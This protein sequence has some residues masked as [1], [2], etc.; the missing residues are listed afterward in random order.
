[1]Q[2]FLK[3]PLSYS[4]LSSW[5]WSKEG[6]Y[7]SYIKGERTSPNSIMLAGSRIGDAIGTESCPIGL[8]PPGVKEYGITTVI[9]DIPLV[10]YFDH[11]C[12]KTRVLHENK[13]S[14]NKS[15]WTQ[16][17]VDKHSQIDMYLLLLRE[18]E[19][20]DPES[21]SCQLNFV[22]LKPVGVGYTLHE[23]PV[24]RSFKTSR[25]NEQIDAYLASVKETV[26]A[27]QA[28]IEA[29]PLS[30]EAPRRPAFKGI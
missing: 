28:Y 13:C 25:T 20:V 9:E 18:A 26:K 5:E 8:N 16:G 23:P 11:Y 15:R 7:Q 22:L 6:W 27:M 29:V 3:R 14:D 24:V 21:V 30:T 19:G 12:N 10:G 2:R 1:M 4:Q 17:K